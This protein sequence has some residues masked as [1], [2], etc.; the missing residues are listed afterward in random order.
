MM[1]KMKNAEMLATKL[2]MAAPLVEGTGGG[3][4]AA[5]TAAGIAADIAGAGI[6]P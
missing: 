4:V 2:T 1:G 6:V 5:D 3:Y